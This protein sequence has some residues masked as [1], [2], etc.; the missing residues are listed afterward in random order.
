MASHVT[1]YAVGDVSPGRDRGELLLSP[2]AS[3]L[4]QADID[5]CQLENPFSILITRPI[6]SVLNPA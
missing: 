5:F 4:K 3:I 1:I 2:S 6:S